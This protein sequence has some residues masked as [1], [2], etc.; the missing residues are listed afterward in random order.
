MAIISGIVYCCRYIKNEWFCTSDLQL[1][2][3]HE[4]VTIF[5]SASIGIGTITYLAMEFSVPV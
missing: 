5:L 4:G 3:L 1:P 2:S